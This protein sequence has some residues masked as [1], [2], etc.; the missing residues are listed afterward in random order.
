M[1]SSGG[2]GNL[3]EGLGTDAPKVRRVYLHLP[4]RLASSL[5]A[6]EALQKERPCF[7]KAGCYLKTNNI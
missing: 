3:G 6:G 1:C 4:T 7:H 5:E 2:A